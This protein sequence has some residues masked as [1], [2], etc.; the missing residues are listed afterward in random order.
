MKF[1]WLLIAL[2]A[3]P[4]GADE[5]ATRLRAALKN[6]DNLSADFK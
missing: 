3:T 1:L 2:V 6:M 4:V 5:A